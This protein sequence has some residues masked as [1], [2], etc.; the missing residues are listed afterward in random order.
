ME[1]IYLD[2]SATTPVDKRVIKEMLPFFDEKY[3]NPSS[4]HL[5]GR[6]VK[7]AIEEAREKI[8][9]VINAEPSEIFFTSGGTESDNLAI[10]G[11]A[12]S[13]KEKGDH[14]ITSTA[15]HH[16]V[17]DTARFLQKNGFKV[18]Y[19]PV[20]KYGIVELEDI[21]E[22]LTPRTILISIMHINNEV[23]S[24]NPISEIGE[25]AR[26]NNVLFH[27][28]AVQSFGKEPIDVKKDNIDL[29]SLSS[30]K[31]YGP[32]GA[33]ALY[34]KRGV[35]PEKIIHGGSQEGNRR[36]GTENVPG[37]IGLRKAA[38]ICL[39]EM[40]NERK[41]LNKLRDYFWEKLQEN[42]PDIYLNGHPKIRLPGILNVSFPGTDSETVL[43]SL[44]LKGI[45]ASGGS[46]CTSGSIEPSHVLKAMGVSPEIAQSAIRFSL[47]RENNK[48]QIDYTVKNLKEIIDYIRKI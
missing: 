39:E 37:I 25:F 33:G 14:I 4:I 21:K 40:E 27:T 45:A 5:F 29:L 42:I 22:A 48:E 35:S 7:T 11:T 8:A 24:I 16:A 17:L 2:H 20:N 3:G 12:L 1:A 10:T 30:H 13:M 6:E 15:E 47:G 28:D 32:K 44:D 18:T 38:E 23:G 41:Y 34:I 26:E 46:A 19:V 9:E 43:I 31:I 36:G